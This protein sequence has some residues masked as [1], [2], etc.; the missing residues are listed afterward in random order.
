MNFYVAGKA[1]DGAD[2]VKAL[3]AR[4]RSLGHSIAFDWAKGVIIEKPYLDH[5]EINVITAKKMRQA[6]VD[7]DH[8]I[9]L[10]GDNLLGAY[11]EFGL[12]LASTST[13][14][15]KRLFVVSGDPLRQSIFYTEPSVVICASIEELL[16]KLSKSD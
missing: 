8:F 7:C 6:A 9:L 4:L 14:P 16:E 2:G 15:D 12:A 11:I 5:I 13:R 3:I 10:V 1:G